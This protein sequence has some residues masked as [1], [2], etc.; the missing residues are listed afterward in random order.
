LSEFLI[1]SHRDTLQQIIRT[2]CK[3]NSASEQIESFNQECDSISNED[4]STVFQQLDD[5]K[6]DF[7]NNDGVIRFYNDIIEEKMAQGQLKQYVTGHPLRV[8]LEENI[9]LR[10]WIKQ[11]WK[12]NP[13]KDL[14]AFAEIFKNISKVELHYQRKENQLFPCLEK[15]GWDSPSKNMWVFHDDN[16]AL[17]KTVRLSIEAGDAK[18]TELKAPHMLNE[19]ERMMLVEEQRLLPNALELL[20]EDDWIDM[21]DGDS[22]IGWMLDQEP[23]PFP[24][25]AEAEQK[26]AAQC[27]FSAAAKEKAQSQAEEQ[28]PKAAA[29]EYVHPSKVKRKKKVPFDTTGMIHVE[30]G[31]LTPE[32]VNLIFKTLPM[33]ITYVD[34]HGKV[35]FYNRGQDRLFPRSPG[36][37]GRGVHLCHPPK[38]VDTVLK[39]VEEFKKGTRDIADFRINIKGR[40]VLIRYFAV[41]DNDRTYRGVM[42]MSQDITD[43]QTL[44]GEQRLLDWD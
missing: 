25:P 13:L 22:E 24:A 26:P 23:A 41:R 7:R 38:S 30:E 1:G 32:Q 29:T 28:I 8:Y 20:D 44:A 16:R 3:G 39:I 31:Y 14:P 40:F 12:C 33:D 10:R 27:P 9:L 18:Q 19:L 36:I 37:I 17:I 15:H 34:E 5:D 6:I 2:L 4:L 42:E 35:L 11:I 21:R 43:I